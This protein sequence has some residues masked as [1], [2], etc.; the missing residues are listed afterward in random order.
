MKVSAR[1]RKI[2]SNIC[3]LWFLI[4]SENIIIGQNNVGKFT[5]LTKIDFFGIFEGRLFE[6]FRHKYRNLAFGWP[7]GN[8]S[9]INARNYLPTHL[10]VM[11]I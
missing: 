1:N 7:V 3:S 11:I 9:S 6:I 10:S 4:D 5:K 2:E 8:V